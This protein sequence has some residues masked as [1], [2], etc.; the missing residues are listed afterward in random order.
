MTNPYGQMA[1]DHW[2]AHRPASLSALADPE[3]YFARLGLV[4]ESQV[5]DLAER[6]LDRQRP[7]EDPAAFLQR[8]GQAR[9]QAEEVVLG[10]LVWAEAEEDPEDPDDEVTAAWHRRLNL[11]SEVLSILAGAGEDPTGPA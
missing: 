11:G 4:A 10:E 5:R 3:D 7:G 2:R 1:W 9:R 8:S 6:I